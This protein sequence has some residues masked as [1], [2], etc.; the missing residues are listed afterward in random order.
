[1]KLQ[2]HRY[3]NLSNPTSDVTMHKTVVSYSCNECENSLVQ[4]NVWIHRV[5]REIV[6][7]M[8]SPVLVGRNF[9]SVDILLIFPL[10]QCNVMTL[11]NNLSGTGAMHF[12]WKIPCK[13]KCGSE[14]MLWISHIWRQLA[15]PLSK[16]PTAPFTRGGMC[17]CVCVCGGG[18]GG[19][20]LKQHNLMQVEQQTYI[21]GKLIV[22]SI[23]PKGRVV[24]KQT[25]YNPNVSF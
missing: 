4:W 16:Y 12:F 15:C 22:V 8:S 2:K 17:V 25:Q 19:G 3:G 24:S 1:M 20:G 21:I 10:C 14:Q 9:S 5:P 13:P 7:T 6:S 23:W 18:G 11:L